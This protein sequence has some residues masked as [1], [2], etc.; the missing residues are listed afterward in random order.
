M[1]AGAARAK[2]VGM[3]ATPCNR[4]M[5]RACECGA[6]AL[7]L[8]AAPG[9]ARAQGISLGWQD[10]RSGGNP[11]FDRQTFLCTTN[12]IQLPLYPGVRLLAPVDSVFSVELVIDVD[13]ASDPMPAWWSMDGTCRSLAWFADVTQAG[14]CADPWNGLGVASVQGWLLGTPRNSNRHARLLVAAGVLAQDAVKL[15]ADVPYTLCRVVL[16]S[17][18]TTPCPTG[19][20]TPACM[21]FNSVLLRRLPGSTVEEV[22]V[23]TPEVAGTNMVLWQP[24]VAGADCASVPVRRSSWSAVKALYR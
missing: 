2:L 10:C 12:T 24:A 13:V 4:A 23:S 6:L 21:V 16:D 3:W 19:C 11:G 22:L 8:L 18:G 1:P 17:R 7:A 14:S 5:A 9:A 20:L 15:D